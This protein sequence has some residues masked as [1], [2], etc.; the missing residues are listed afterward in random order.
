MSKKSDEKYL[1]DMVE[2]ARQALTISA[3]VD[4]ARFRSDRTLQLA[5]AHAVQ[6][7]GEAAYRTSETTKAALPS[8]P[9]EKII[10]MRHRLVHDYGNVSYG[11][12]WDVVTDHLADLIATL[13]KFTPPEQP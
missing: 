7:V 10:G 3:G 2:Y 9:W 12:V 6:I 13:E 11:V 1:S 4:S 8:I 5:L